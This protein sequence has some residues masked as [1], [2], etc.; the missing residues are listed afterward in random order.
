MFELAPSGSSVTLHRFVNSLFSYPTSYDEG[1]VRSEDEGDATSMNVGDVVDP[2]TT[3]DRIIPYEDDLKSFLEQ[4]HSTD[5]DASS[6]SETNG[7]ESRELVPS[8]ADGRPCGENVGNGG[9]ADAVPCI[10]HVPGEVVA[11]P[12]LITRA[13]GSPREDSTDNHLD[14]AALAA[15]VSHTGILDRSPRK[16]GSGRAGNRSHRRQRSVLP[17]DFSDDNLQRHLE[18]VEAIDNE[19]STADTASLGGARDET[20]GGARVDC[21]PRNRYDP[22]PRHRFDTSPRNRF[23]GS[24]RGHFTA[25]PRKHFAVSPRGHLEASPRRHFEVSPRKRLGLSPK[26]MLMLD[27]SNPACCDGLKNIILSPRTPTRY[28]SVTSNN[29]LHNGGTVYLCWLWLCTG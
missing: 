10:D 6:V 16:P 25:S 5:A 4:V 3:T 29:L 21:S 15:A 19:G 17:A 26:P 2:T 7:Q 8:R 1:V 13:L 28:E 27:P 24:P 11:F 14:M 22:S 23:D 9:V 20:A 12:G 18:S